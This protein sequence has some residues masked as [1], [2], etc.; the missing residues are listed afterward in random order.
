MEVTSKGK[1]DFTQAL[2]IARKCRERNSLCGLC[3]AGVLL[4]PRPTEN[5]AFPG[6]RPSGWPQPPSELQGSAR[7]EASV[8]EGKLSSLWPRGLLHVKLEETR[9]GEPDTRCVSGMEEARAPS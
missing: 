1:L 3:P 8:A 4:G 6:D 5:G 9:S 2:S 7:R